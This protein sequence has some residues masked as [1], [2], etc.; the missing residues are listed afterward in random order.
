LCRHYLGACRAGLRLYSL[1]SRMRVESSREVVDCA[2]RIVR[3]IINSYA[4]PNKAFAELLQMST[5]EELLDP[6]CDFSEACRKE[7]DG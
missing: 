4:Q 1:I 7:L 3:L 2:Q 6:L 5:N